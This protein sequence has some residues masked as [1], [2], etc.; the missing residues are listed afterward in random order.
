[1]KS[2]PEIIQLN[3]IPSTSTHLKELLKQQTLTECSVVITNNQ[4]AGR[5]Q[6]GNS[7]ESAPG[8]NLSFSI[9]LYP[10]MVAPA[11]QFIIS[12]TIS[13][14]LAVALGKL[15]SPIE[16]KW[17]ND[18]Y[19]NNKKL[20]GILI[21]NSLN[22][23]LISQSVVGIGIN[24]NQINFSSTIP[25]PTSMKLISGKS[26]DLKNVFLQL[27]QSIL[28]HYENLKEENTN[29]IE[30]KYLSFLYRKTGFFKYRDKTGE[31]L[32]SINKIGPA[33]HLYLTRSNGAISKYAF[34]E[35]EFIL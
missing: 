11:H 32:A 9:V 34:K 16:I 25:N 28:E 8:K 27:Y 7:W 31:F 17:P 15:I 6:P 29:D 33:G 18:I 23:N 20:G 30:E 13:V 12:K 22:G 35:V 21:E 5:G 4:T 26:W 19:Y 24:I 3:S 1:M 14:A 10:D 2:V